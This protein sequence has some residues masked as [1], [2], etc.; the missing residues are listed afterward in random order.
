MTWKLLALSIGGA[1]VGDWLSTA[2]F[3]KSRGTSGDRAGSRAA[4]MAVLAIGS[5]TA[6][7][8]RQTMF[9]EIGAAA[10]GVGAIY[11]WRARGK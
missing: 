6:L 11:W 2:F 7:A 4:G 3:E 5:V 10:A 1:L 8:S 9:R